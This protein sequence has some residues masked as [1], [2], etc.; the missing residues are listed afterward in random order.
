MGVIFSQGPEIDTTENRMDKNSFCGTFLI[1]W[2]RTAGKKRPGCWP[3][4]LLC[5]A[6]TAGRNRL[7]SRWL[8]VPPLRDRDP[9]PRRTPPSAPSLLLDRPH[10]L[11]PP[12][13]PPGFKNTQQWGKKDCG[14]NK[15]CV[16]A[17]K[18]AYLGL[19][20]GH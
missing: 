12:P 17:H 2:T 13:S 1:T 5:S 9:R 18:C 10:S 8:P 11:P 20:P 15:G 6:A 16:G 7:R 19:P 4:N 14:F 3:V